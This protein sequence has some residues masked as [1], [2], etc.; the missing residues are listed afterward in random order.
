M[1]MHEVPCFLC[2]DHVDSLGHI[3]KCAVARKVW[4]QCLHPLQFSSQELLGFVD[5][6]LINRD[7]VFIACAI[8]IIFEAYRFWR[9]HDRH[10]HNHDACTRTIL[11][12]AAGALHGAR[13]TYVKQFVARC[14]QV[15]NSTMRG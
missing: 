5:R 12:H 9:H 11:L 3:S 10:S 14:T 13:N 8:F 1:G 6:E 7:R 2:N 15:L 4:Q